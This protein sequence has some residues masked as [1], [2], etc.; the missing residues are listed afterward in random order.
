LT[1]KQLVEKKTTRTVLD[2]SRKINNY[3]R[4]TGCVCRKAV[5]NGVNGFLVPVKDS[6]ALKEAM[7]KVIKE[8]ELIQ[9]MGA[10]S[11]EIAENKYDVHKVNKVI[12]ETM[13]L[14]SSQ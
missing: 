2:S 9:E 5:K 6:R 10:K 7:E 8:P 13:G 4:Y 1:L 11:R 14:I 3:Y 12:N